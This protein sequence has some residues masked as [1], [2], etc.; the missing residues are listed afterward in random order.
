MRRRN[1]LK[2]ILALAGTAGS[3]GVALGAYLK[4]SVVRA[5]TAIRPPGALGEKLFRGACVHCGLCVE[6]CPYGILKLATLEEPVATGT[7]YFTARDNPCEMCVDI[8][9]VKACPTGALN[10]GLTDIREARMG[11]AVF[12]GAE[13]CY[14][15]QGTACRSCY[16]ACPLKNDA[17]TMTQFTRG[18]KTVFQPTVHA[19][20]CTGCGKCEEACITPAAS[21]KVLPL[22]MARKDSGVDVHG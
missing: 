17:I 14:A 3:I 16:M 2:S 8:P 5:A 11:L 7:P 6:A 20:A 18:K 22:A 19:S 10:H 21:I 1:F 4:S 13:T 15:M 9:C 12:T